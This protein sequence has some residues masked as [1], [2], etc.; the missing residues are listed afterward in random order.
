MRRETLAVALLATA[1]FLAYAWSAHFWVEQ[2]DEGY[3]LDM[4]DRVVRGELPYR[5]FTTYYTPGIFYLFAA[6][7]KLFGANLLWPRYLMALLRVATLL[8]TYGLA[9]RVAPWPIALLPFVVLALL[10]H[11]PI[12]PEPHPSWPAIVLCLA[13]MECAARHFQS[14]RPIWLAL[15]GVCAALSFLFKQNIGAFTAIAL[16]GYIVLR[17]RVPLSAAMK[18]VQVLFALGAAAAVTMLMLPAI[19]A[20]FVACLLLPFF[21]ALALALWPS[22]HTPTGSRFDGLR[23]VTREGLLAAALF[24]VVTAAWIV[25]LAVAL[26]PRNVPFNLFLGSINEASIATPLDPL[27]PGIH[28][29]A[30]IAIWVPV[31]LVRTRQTLIA[32]I[33]LSAL[34]PLLPIH[35]GR[36]DPVTTDALLAAPSA[37]LDVNF[38]TWNVYLPALAAWAGI[39]AV[40]A[41]KASGPAIWYLLFGVSASLALFPRADTL[42]ALVVGPPIFVASAYALA[43][44][45]TSVRRPILLAA[46]AIVP[47]L[48]IAPQV[49]WRLATIV[50]PEKG[51]P[52]LAYASLD[53]PRAPVDVPEL[54]AADLRDTVAYID[55]HTSPGD[56]ILAYPV[57]PIFNFLADRPN[58]TRFD[59]FI[60]GTLTDDDFHKVIASIEQAR[61]RYLIWDHLNVLL[62]ATDPINRPLSD[63]IFTCYREV[64]AYN[65]YLVMERRNDAC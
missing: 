57:N 3:F 54:W 26:G 33:L 10:D 50:G 8:L 49:A 2:V 12:E 22:L 63:Y 44:V 56:P 36:R 53:L 28:V 38:G 16:G 15:A 43:C 51:Q 7:F 6:T 48:A 55:V 60:P 35:L 61:P 64:Q 42:H 4:A 62:Y 46:L 52:R 30:L 65:R 21:A 47:V 39:V 11:W 1:T 34:F 20:L 17:P 32:A 5:D 58:P 19:D 45:W 37:W 18:T 27:S 40:A 31:L 23:Q 13:T 59:H 25:P 14:G 9:R 29:V 24:C 41:T